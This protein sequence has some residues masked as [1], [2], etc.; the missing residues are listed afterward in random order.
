MNTIRDQAK[1][2]LVKKILL[3]A[4]F[5]VQKELGK[6]MSP[7][8]KLLSRSSDSHP[9]DEQQISASLRLRLQNTCQEVCY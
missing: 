2:D 1:A 9:Y 5:G 7:E 8:K 3:K 4:N 6:H